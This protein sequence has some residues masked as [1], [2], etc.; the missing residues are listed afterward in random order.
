MRRFGY[1]HDGLFRGSLATYAVN[2]LVVL[3]HLAGFIHAHLHWAWPFLHSHLDD[4]LLMPA[5]LPVMLWLQRI[6]GLRCHD[7]PP[8]LAEMLSHLAI[9]SVMCKIIGPLYFN[10]GTADAWDIWFFAAGGLVAWRWWN[11]PAARSGI[12]PA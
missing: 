7:H 4:L 9:W 2:R 1:L 8:S 10:I 12:V 6:T 5:A 3:P 11:R